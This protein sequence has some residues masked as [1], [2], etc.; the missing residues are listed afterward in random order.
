MYSFDIF[1]TLITRS[2]ADPKGIFM[3]M[4]KDMKETEEYDSFLLSNFYELRTGAENLAR[5]YAESQ[6]KQEVTLDDIY[7]AMATTAC[8][9]EEQQEKLKKLEIEIE[10]NN[11]LGLSKNIDLL[12]KLKNEG[13]H[14]VLISD[15]YLS[16]NHIRAM[17]ILFFE[18]FRFMYLPNMERQR[19]AESFFDLLKKRKI[20]VFQIGFITVIMNMQI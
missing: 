17:W 3:L 13:Q 19:E 18:I 16:E 5:R 10:C 2:T 20:Q 12:K 11:V 14:L 7:D 6:G 9:T 8:V 15:M 4:Q 1:D